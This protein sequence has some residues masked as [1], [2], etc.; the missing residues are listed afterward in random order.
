[1]P[2]DRDFENACALIEEHCIEYLVIAKYGNG[3]VWKESNA[4]FG[5]GAATR[6]LASMDERERHNVRVEL[7]GEDIQ[8]DE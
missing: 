3:L 4:T 2:M 8:E 6:Y 5:V 1:M 7:T